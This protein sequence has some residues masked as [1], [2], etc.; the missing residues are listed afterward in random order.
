MRAIKFFNGEF[1]HVYSRGVDKREIFVNEIDRWRFMHNVMLAAKK[2]DLSKPSQIAIH[3]FCLMKNHYHLLIE[4][5]TDGGV[6]NFMH[7]LNT[8]Y[9]MYFNKKYQRTGSLLES[10]YKAKYVSDDP[11]LIVLSRYIHLN[12][13]DD[14]ITL[15]DYFWSSF[16]DYCGESTFPFITTTT[17]MSYFK[18]P[19]EY[20]TFVCG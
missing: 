7:R 10:T 2:N 20:E 12:P 1:Y 11:Y 13:A 8:A 3:A 17:V 18:T 16:R 4:Q 19:K 6:S 15:K 14:F 5:K 9:T